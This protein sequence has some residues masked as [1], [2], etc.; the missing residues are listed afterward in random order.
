MTTDTDH[1]RRVAFI[2]GAG[3]GIGR[4]TAVR[5][6]RDGADICIADIDLDGA[7]ETASLV[8]EFGRDAH[9]V[10]CNVASLDQV[11]SAADECTQQL[12]G[13]DIAVANAGI[14]RGGIGA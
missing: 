3:S 5:L 9:V 10:Q 11:Q 1:A 14:G 13:I 8:R 12:G 4:G 6:A 2:T 7:A